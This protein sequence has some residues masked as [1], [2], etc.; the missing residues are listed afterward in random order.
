MYSFILHFFQGFV[1]PSTYLGDHCLGVSRFITIHI[2][3]HRKRDE[4]CENIK[5][6]I[7]VIT[8]IKDKSKA[9]VWSLHSYS[10]VE[11]CVASTVLICSAVQRNENDVL[12]SNDTGILRKRNSEFSQ[13]ESNLRPPI[14][15]SDALPL[16]YRRLVG[17]EAIKLGS[18]DK[19][20]TKKY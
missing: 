18:W 12:F 14:T 9:H 1:N 11:L 16:S 5:C 17:A 6:S 3:I 13:Q 8:I 4:P 7:E 15:S 10:Y 20:P 19:H 2:K